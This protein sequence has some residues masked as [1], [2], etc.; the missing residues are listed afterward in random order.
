MEGDSAAPQSMQQQ[1][2]PPRLAR[3]AKERVPVSSSLPPLVLRSVEH[4]V[5]A[6]REF[7]GV[8]VSSSLPPLVLRSVEHLV[9]ASREFVGL[10]TDSTEQVLRLRNALNGLIESLHMTGS[11]GVMHQ[12]PSSGVPRLIVAGI[13][14]SGKS[15]LIS[16]LL[17]RCAS[18]A[19]SMDP[20]VTVK[21]DVDNSSNNTTT[22]ITTSSNVRRFSL[23]YQEWP[24]TRVGGGSSGTSRINDSV[25]TPRKTS[26]SSRR[27]L[28]GCA[29]T[30]EH[31][32]GGILSH[33]KQV[34]LH[35]DV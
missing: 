5:N 6:S 15:T 3:T 8:P 11:G 21:D 27:R 12:Y 20:L 35:A 9:N 28:N 32:E 19:A 16:F 24:P 10:L 7:V 4:L 31:V 18:P 2:P 14:Q 17:Q 13:P 1:L 29:A 33:A 23:G 26:L 34:F 22:T 30:E 25:V